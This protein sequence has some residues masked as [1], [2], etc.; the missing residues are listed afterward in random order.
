MKATDE[1]EVRRGGR[2]LR[3]ESWWW[4]GSM[5]YE[6]MVGD[7]VQEEQEEDDQR[8]TRTQAIR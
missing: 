3:E 8:M 5:E 7:G 2:Q 4:W 6:G 1:M